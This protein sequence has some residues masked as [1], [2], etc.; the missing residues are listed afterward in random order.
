MGTEI[1]KIITRRDTSAN[2]E[3]NNPILSNGE[4]GVDITNRTM[5][6]GD[7]VTPWKALKVSGTTVVNDLTT[8]GA[9]KAL[10]AEMGKEIASEIKYSGVTFDMNTNR[11]VPELYITGLDRSKTY[12]IY[13]INNGSAERKVYIYDD[14]D[15]EPDIFV[16]SATTTDFSKNILQIIGATNYPNISGFVIV[17]WDIVPEGLTNLFSVIRHE[18]V[19]NLANNPRIASEIQLGIARDDLNN[20]INGTIGDVGVI[21]SSSYYNGYYEISKGQPNP[22]VDGISVFSDI[23]YKVEGGASYRI[24]GNSKSY[25]VEVV[26]YDSNKEYL[27]SPNYIWFSSIDRFTVPTSCKYVRIAFRDTAGL[28]SD[29][30]EGNIRIISEDVL[31]DC[32][33]DDLFTDDSKKALS[34]SIGKRFATIE[35]NVNSVV[36]GTIRTKYGVEDLGILNNGRYINLHTGKQEGASTCIITNSIYL[37]AGDMITAYTGGTGIAVIAKSDSEATASTVFTPL[38]AADNMGYPIT[39]RV[40]EAGHYAFSG[41]NQ[42]QGEAALYVEV[43][44]HSESDGIIHELEGKVDDCVRKVDDLVEGKIEVKEYT[45]DDLQGAGAN[46]GYYLH[47][48]TLRREQA[49]NCIITA[50]LYLNIGDEVDCKIGGGTGLCLFARTPSGIINNS[51]TDCI[52]ISGTAT[53]YKGVISEA[54]WY[55]FS[56]RI[57]RTDGT[58]LVVNVKAYKRGESLQDKLDKKVDKSDIASLAG[59]NGYALSV[60]A[61]MVKD[62]IPTNPWFAEVS[63]DGTTYGTYLDDKIDSVPEG[64]SFIFISDVHYRGNMKQSAK[65]IDYVRRRLGIKTVIHGG[66]VI[67]ESPTIA[68]AAKEWLD[69][70]RD[71][72]FRLGGDFKQACGDHDH[73]GKYADTG[74]ALSYQFVQ[75]VLNGY[76]IKELHY[77]TLYDEQVAEIASSN[78]W[79]ENDIKEYNAWKK[80]HYYFDDSTINT[81]FIVLHTGWTGDVGMAVEKLGSGVLSEAQALYLQMDFLHQSLLS[82]PS[83]Y[84]VVVIGHNAIGNKSYS[85]TVDGTSVVRYNVNEPVWKGTWQQV[86]KM[87][88]AFKNKSSVGLQYRDWSGS[89]V[90]TKFFDFAGANTPNVVFCMGGDVHWDIIGKSTENSETLEPISVATS[91]DKIIVT[92]GSVS[93]SDIPHILTMTDGGDRGYR[94]IIA[95]IGSSYNDTT[96]SAQ[97]SASNTAGTLDAQ[98]FDIVTVTDS[99]IYLT[100]IGSG[101]D[102]VIHIE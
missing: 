74:Q 53:S 3:S 69:F 41:R 70:N 79:T 46:I 68:E 93:A 85:T 49:N 21:P 44:R 45:L 59:G 34:A 102:R 77:D 23:A 60:G 98:A 14:N 97:L 20:K 100:R 10:S 52:S 1:K 55:V 18:A 76:N 81:R 36:G 61:D 6:I 88:R 56:G 89:G 58:N 92:E 50:P 62:A 35:S 82:A 30:F 12:N 27:G 51:T 86:A 47:Q 42:Q 32:I 101:N 9:D 33:A 48:T 25:M 84:N 2:W 13:Q 96:D 66:D 87:I 8:G 57:N 17:N 72:V 73:N 78:G 39:Y 90:Q 37:E 80:M 11:M 54:G 24:L 83:N 26:F 15:P 95:P 5:K 22:S 63:N 7:G 19:N 38:V 28:T 67:N 40:D 91:L 16:A 75:R 4:L 31:S 43:L 29:T 94:G 64:D 99:E 65:L 71:F